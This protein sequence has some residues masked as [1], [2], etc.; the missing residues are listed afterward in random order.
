MPRPRKQPLT[1]LARDLQRRAQFGPRNRARRK[2]EHAL[3]LPPVVD[4]GGGDEG[5]R[6]AA[7]EVM[8]QRAIRQV[9][10]GLVPAPHLRDQD[11]ERRGRVAAALFQTEQRW[12]KL[13]FPTRR[14]DICREIVF[15]SVG[16]FR[17]GYELDTYQL[18]AEALRQIAHDYAMLT[19]RRI[20]DSEEARDLLTKQALVDAAVPAAG[21]AVTLR[22]LL[23]ML[24]FVIA[25]E[26]ADDLPKPTAE[27]IEKAAEAKTIGEFEY[28][29]TEVWGAF[30]LQD[31]LERVSSLLVQSLRAFALMLVAA[32]EVLP[33]LETWDEAGGADQA[34]TFMNRIINKSPFGD[35]VEL[36]RLRVAARSGEIADF[37]EF[38]GQDA[39]SELLGGWTT[40]IRTCECRM[41]DEERVKR[42]DGL[43]PG[44]DLTEEDLQGCDS[45]CAPHATR[46]AAYGLLEL[47]E[48]SAL[49]PEVMARI[50]SAVA[51][52]SPLVDLAR[53][54]K[55]D[56]YFSDGLLHNEE[57]A[58]GGA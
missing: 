3:A 35:P 57:S 27:E 5:D 48:F 36:S 13:D 58:H 28:E 24:P 6:V 14:R 10:D 29:H 9:R 45:F 19:G 31:I 56:L 8:L 26:N 16:G 44:E 39:G 42:G 7:F 4:L 51:R 40:W 49:P 43:D 33:K 2:L 23:F 32:Q 22:S 38:V 20:E 41:G 54:F 30:R 37:V 15:L 11:F 47:T 21:L 18:V 55:R 34:A 1:P 46:N 53:A 12:A 52:T 50:E 25:L 17:Q